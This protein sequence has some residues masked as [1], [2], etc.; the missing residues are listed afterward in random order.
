MATSTADNDAVAGAEINQTFAAGARAYVGGN[1]VNFPMIPSF[2]GPDSQAPQYQDLRTVII[3]QPVW[4]RNQLIPFSRSCEG[5]QIRINHL[6]RQDNIYE[7]PRS[8]RGT[9]SDLEKSHLTGPD[10]TIEVLL[11]LPKDRQFIASCFMTLWSEDKDTTSFDLLMVGSNRALNSRAHAIVLT[12]QGCEKRMGASGWGVGFNQNHM[13]TNGSDANVSIGGLGYSKGES[14]N[15][16][17]PWIQ[18]IGIRF[19]NE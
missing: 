1:V 4:T 15:Q 7:G 11:E 16:G 14:R 5:A 17:Y 18:A 9:L 2:F 6:R 10:A 8:K 13:S 19:I 12:A 3:V